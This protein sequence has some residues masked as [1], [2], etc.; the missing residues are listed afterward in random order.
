MVLLSY[1]FL[2]KGHKTTGSCSE[3]QS[4]LSSS[5]SAKEYVES[6]HQNA[7]STLLYGKNNVVIQPV[8]VAAFQFLDRLLPMPT[9]LW[10]VHWFDFGNVSQLSSK[11]MHKQLCCWKLL[12]RET[13]QQS[14]I[15][16][17]WEIQICVFFSCFWPTNEEKGWSWGLSVVLLESPYPLS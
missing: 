3:D 17:A 12:I 2:F 11:R 13:S 10:A 6:L 14:S 4:R 15:V 5:T 1:F 9:G 16:W 7:K 8:C